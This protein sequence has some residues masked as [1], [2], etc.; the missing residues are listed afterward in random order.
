ML[1]FGFCVYVCHPSWVCVY[2][3]DEWA[4]GVRV[5]DVCVMFPLTLGIVP[6]GELFMVV[7]LG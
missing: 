2:Q 7:F 4:F 6:L 1:G 3:V 5:W